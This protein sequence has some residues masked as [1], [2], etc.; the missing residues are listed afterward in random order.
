TVVGPAVEPGN[1]PIEELDVQISPIQIDPVDVGDLELASVRRADGR[2]DIDDILVVDVEAGH[3][4]LRL[5]LGR[6]LLERDDP[7]VPIELNHSVT[8]RVPHRVSE[9]ECARLEAGDDLLQSGPPVE[10][11]VA[12]D[13]SHRITVD[14]V[15]ADDEG[16]GDSLRL[17]LNRVGDV[18]TPG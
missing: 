7:A 10:D 4:I 2:G 18:D 6:L 12:E 15:G 17:G 16:L 3:R 8:L 1:S 14:E 13:E 11:V 9:H 5:R